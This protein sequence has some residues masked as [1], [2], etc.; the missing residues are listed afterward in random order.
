[1]CGIA[2]I[3]Y[4][5]GNGPVGP[6]SPV[7]KMSRALQ[8]RGPDG[9]GFVSVKNGMAVP[10]HSDHTPAVNINSGTFRFNPKQD[11]R[12]G[13]ETAELIFAHRRLSI[14]DL[15]EAG[16]QPMCDQD[17]KIWIT[18]NGEI[19]NYIEIRRYLELQGYRFATNTDTEVIIHAYQH[20][21]I[22]CLSQFNGMWAFALYDTNTGHVFCA[23][24]RVG[25]KP[26]YYHHSKEIFAFASEH[27]AFLKAGVL[28]FHPDATQE[29]EFL[30]N[31][32]IEHRPDSLFNGIKELEPGHY[33]LYNKKEHTLETK[34]YFTQTITHTQETDEHEIIQNI[35]ELVMK[36]VELRL[37]SDVEVGS[38][39]SG[40]IDSSAIA[41][42]VKHL[43][44]ARSMQLFTSVFDS[45]SFDESRFASAV[46][47][48]VNGR[49]HQVSP[50]ATEFFSNMENLVYY[51]DIP[52]WSTST[53]SQYRVMKLAGQS[54]IK[55]LLDGQGADE[56]FSGYTHHYLSY[57]KELI[58][59]GKY[60]EA[61]KQM[62]TAKKTL[63]GSSKALLKQYAKEFLNTSID[64]SGY[65]KSDA[66]LPAATPEPIFSSLNEQLLHDYAG[67]RL[68]SYLKCE[69]RCSMTFSIESRVPF[70]DD[71]E[72]VN[73]LFSIPSSAKI[74][75]GTLKYLLREAVRDFLPKEVYQRR[76]KTGFETPQVK[77]LLEGETQVLEALSAE[78]EMIRIDK[79]KK[80]Y[81]TIVRS[82]PYFVMRLYSLAIWKR[83][84]KAI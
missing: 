22:E 64:Y 11:I 10:L 72:L 48:R 71:H 70:A 52:L 26:F 40:G 2:G 34:K 8:H 35:R 56:I 33:L 39:L 1:M 31:A 45:E 79:F 69:D 25:V 49:W 54:G 13:N 47:A 20:W 42:I 83:V 12:N 17:A 18:Y 24:D 81:K 19:Y 6:D 68:K 62:L 23:R 78:L 73:Y 29:M 75:D 46:A 65:F 60:L 3:I 57:W 15:T 84:F 38:C 53:Y 50:T 67:G 51:Q 16:H 21:G 80:G 59:D 4:H 77:W 58:R 82:R 32:R 14:I 66:A 7:F 63:P 61:R 5:S 41:G 74:K 9:E 76:D 44:P 36:S 28:P 43:Q 30:I 55:V 37:R 27:K